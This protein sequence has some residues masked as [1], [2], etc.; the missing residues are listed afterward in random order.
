MFSIPPIDAFGISDK[1]LRRA[2]NEDAYFLDTSRGCFAVADGVGGGATGE[3]A[4]RLFVA[5]VADRLALP[6]MSSPSSALQTVKDIFLTANSNIIDYSAENPESA[7]MACT[8]ELLFFCEEG[9]VLGHIGD[10]RTYRLRGRE[11]VRLTKDHSF[12]QEQLNLGN[13]TEE[14]ARNHR[15]RNVIL[16][17]VGTELEINVDIIHGR[18]Q[19]GDIFLLCS[20]GLTDMV[21]EKLISECL[22]DAGNLQQKGR[23]L[24]DYANR[25]GGRDN[26]TVILAAVL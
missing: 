6:H 7:G 24:V 16:R 26:I 8:A 12:V 21:E 4:S 18:S 19:P 3:I 14:E 20:D 13:I 23:L 10:S 9:F 1:G 2:L 15:Y 17:A 11:L 25:S 22:Q 5:A